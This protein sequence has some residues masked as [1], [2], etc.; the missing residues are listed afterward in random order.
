MQIYTWRIEIFLMS[1]E[2]KLISQMSPVKE[3]INYF[4]RKHG[5]S[6]KAFEDRIAHLPEDFE[7]WDD[8]IEWKAY[9]DSLNAFSASSVSQLA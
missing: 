5:C 9:E 2:S 6:L 8:F 1:E 3:R 7:R 4:E